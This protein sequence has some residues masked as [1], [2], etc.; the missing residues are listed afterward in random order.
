M[1]IGERRWKH[2][3]ERSWMHVNK[4]ISTR[5]KEI[6]LEHAS[7]WACEKR[8]IE[9]IPSPKNI[10]QQTSLTPKATK[11]VTIIKERI[12]VTPA[13]LHFQ[14]TTKPEKQENTIHFII[15]KK[16]GILDDQSRQRS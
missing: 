4:R 5:T 16:F 15:K 13:S 2:I 3:G 7:K 12:S 9:R 6:R 10:R 1:H 14:T 11:R 8:I